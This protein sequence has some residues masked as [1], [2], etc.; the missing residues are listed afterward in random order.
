MTPLGVF[1]GEPAKALLLRAANPAAGLGTSASGSAALACAAIAAAFG[2]QLA[3]N[4]RYLTAMARLLAGS[5]CRSAAGG[6]ALWLSYPGVPHE[7]SFA[8]RL[9]RNNQLA[10]MRLL[11]IPLDSRIGLKTEQLHEDAP[12]SALIEPWMRGRR[13]EILRAITAAGDGDWLTLAQQ[14]ETD[15]IVQMHRGKMTGGMEHKIF[16]W[17]PENITLFRMCDALRAE[18]VRVY[19][20]TRSGRPWCSYWQRPTCRPWRR[21]CARLG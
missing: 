6:V 12:R 20:S 15:S 4:E 19:F 5:G 14:A 21:G 10:G 1:A 13:V 2:P 3:A 7:D 11:T 9:D 8:L 17:E 16:A 18:G